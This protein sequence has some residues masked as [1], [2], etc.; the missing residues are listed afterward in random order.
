MR[1]LRLVPLL[2]ALLALGACSSTGRSMAGTPAKGPAAPPPSS[3]A[4][5]SIVGTN[6]LHGGVLQRGDRGGLAL[7]SGYVSN[8][9]AA[10]ARDGGAVVLLD[11]GDM[12]QGTLE[13]NLTEGSVVIAAYNRLGYAAAAIGNH[14]FDFGPVGPA[15][16]PKKPGDD[17]RGALKARA[18]QARFPFLAANLIDT[19]TGQPVAFPNV[20]PST[21]IVAAGMKVGVVGVMTSRALTATIAANVQ[22]LRVAPLADTVDQQARRLRADGASIVIVAAHAG[23]RC[24]DFSQPF[25]LTSCDQSEEIFQL[26]RALQPG[27]VDA[28]VAGHVHDGIGHQANGVA[29]TEAYTGGRAFGRIDLVVD[30]AANRIVQRRSFAPRDL[31]ARVDPGTT[32]CD[33][34]GV[35]ATRVPAEYEGAAVTPDPAIAGDLAPGIT[36]AAEQKGMPLGI[37]LATPLRRRPGAAESAL[38]DLVADAYLA[39]MPGAD[40]VINNTDGSLRADLPAG[41]LTYGSV[42]ELMPFDNQLV[43]FHLTGA[44]LRRMI[45]SWLPQRYPATPGFAGLRV[46]VT[47]SGSAPAIVILRPNDQPVRDDE[48]LLVATTDFLANG[49]DRVF[50]AVTPPGGFTIERDVGAVRDLIV[51]ALRKRGGTLREEQLIDPRNARWTLPGPRPVTCGG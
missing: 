49:G 27:L 18:A 6:D 26:V 44:E 15:P 29:I 24:A 48:R 19:S 45:A 1:V 20:R 13:S 51:D 23:A 41:P 16:T 4:I 30:R 42:F 17:P 33:P 46:R 5:I 38:G 9:R 31:C 35:S 47:C 32:R 37:T 11:A 39:G 2:C 12:F 14:E 8:L 50:D 22:G 25:D 40:V 10:R 34:D 3:T 28:I 7:L 36:A 21:T 43:A